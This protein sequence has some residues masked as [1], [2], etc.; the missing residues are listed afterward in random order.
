MTVGIEMIGVRRL[1]KAWDQRS[2]GIDNSCN[3]D[4]DERSVSMAPST[5]YR[6]GQIFNKNALKK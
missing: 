1:G 4:N 3:M 6:N 5:M 2:F